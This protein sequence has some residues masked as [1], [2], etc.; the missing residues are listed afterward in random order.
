VVFR[1]E[2]G[3][4]RLGSI[5]PHSIVFDARG[6]AIVVGSNEIMT[7]DTGSAGSWFLARYTRRGL[8]C[9]FGN[10]GLVL[11]DARGGASAAAIQADGRIVVVGDRQHRFMA[12]RYM[13]NG[14]PR[15]C[16]GEGKKRPARHRHRH[17]HRHKPTRHH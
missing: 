2:Q 13:G 15:T 9:S 5:E 4:G 14:A 16:P 7:I 3:G 10:N 11:G 12:A 6:N 17:G 8:D 1:D